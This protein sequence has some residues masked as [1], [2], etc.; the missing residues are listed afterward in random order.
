MLV[1]SRTYEI[2]FTGRAGPA[3]CA[4]FEDCTVIVGQDTTTLRAELPDQGALRGLFQRIIGLGLDLVDLH[5]L[6]S[7]SGDRA[8]PEAAAA[9][10][11]RAP[12]SVPLG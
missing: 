5:L 2:T 10:R 4:A 11:G 6:R 7:G 9:R 12:T 8:A 3:V 1:R